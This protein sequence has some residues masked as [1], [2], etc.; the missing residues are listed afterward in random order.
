MAYRH[1]QRRQG[2]LFPKSIEDYV[3]DDSPV[4]A[5]DAI[6]DTLDLE[7]LGIEIDPHKVGCPQYHPLPMLKLLVYGYSYGIR[8]SRKLEREC[9]NNISFIWLMGD[10]KPDHKTIAEF[11][12]KNKKAL[13][14]VLREVARVCMALKLV[15]GNTLFVDGTKIRASAAISNS[16]TKEKCGRKLKKIDKRIAEILKECE[17]ADQQE[18]ACG[19]FVKVKEELIDQ[20]TLRSKVKSILNDIEQQSRPSV[21]TVDPDCT[22]MHSRQGN[23]AGFNS[24]IVVDEKHGLIV[25]SDVVNENN[26]K[27]QFADQIDQA[28]EVLGKK[29]DTACGDAGYD[30]IE[31][32]E[33]VDKQGIKVVV[34]SQRQTANKEI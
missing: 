24:Q 18:S 22:K 10:L 2:V 14:N 9:H 30:N 11:R 26:D 32:L 23:H 28:N 7:Q 27:H 12:R 29:C 33:K 21:N 15:E 34:P 13:Q 5:Y 1:G 3:L 6:I 31:E 8:S 4:R 25:S 17:Q 20:E 19:S 16:W